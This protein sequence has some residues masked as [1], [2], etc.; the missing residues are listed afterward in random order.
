M[1]INSHTLLALVPLITVMNFSEIGII[2]TNA[3][4]IPEITPVKIS[5]STSLTQFRQEALQEHNL[6]SLCCL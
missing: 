2:K 3:Q 1:K 6:V 5:Q 4:K